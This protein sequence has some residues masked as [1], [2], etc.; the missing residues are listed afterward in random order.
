MSL[1]FNFKSIPVKA[2][3]PTEQA[4]FRKNSIYQDQSL[5]L[6]TRIENGFQ[7]QEKTRRR[8]PGLLISVPYHI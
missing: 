1:K 3:L 4:G 6:A 7:R 8:L 2:S 5:A